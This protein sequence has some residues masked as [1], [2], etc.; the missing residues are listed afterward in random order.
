MAERIW[1]PGPEAHTSLYLENSACTRS[2]RPHINTPNTH[3]SSMVSD[4]GQ[5]AH[6]PSTRHRAHWPSRPIAL[7]TLHITPAHCSCLLLSFSVSLYSLFL[8]LAIYPF[9]FHYFL[10]SQRAL[11]YAFSLALV[12]GSPSR[13]HPNFP[14]LFFRLFFSVRL[15]DD[16][17]SF[18]SP[19]LDLLLNNDDCLSKRREREK[20]EEE[21]AI[22]SRNRLYRLGLR[23]FPMMN[24][25]I[26]S[27]SGC[28]LPT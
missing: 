7:I 5:L 3:Y 25:P 15:P 4:N 12:P 17:L 27:S 21:K 26:S 23:I 1:S 11:Y 8:S 22:W 6:P 14:L 20:K 2:K 9:I 24:S 19:N 16:L 13:P 28:L 10:A 18:F